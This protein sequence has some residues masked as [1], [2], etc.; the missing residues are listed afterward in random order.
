MLKQVYATSALLVSIAGLTAGG[1]FRSSPSDPLTAWLREQGA[2][3]STDP[4]LPGNPIVEVNFRHGGNVTDDDLARIEGLTEL[5][6]L[7]VPDGT[8]DAGMTR[9]GRLKKLQWLGLSYT[10][11]SDDGL[12]VVAGFDRL[13]TLDLGELTTD[14]G[15]AHLKGLKRLKDLHLQKASISDAGLVVVGQLEDL[16]FLSLDSTK[17]SDAGLKHIKGLKH[18]TDLGLRCTKVT[19]AG[20]ADLV[21]LPLE[22]LDLLGTAITDAG[23]VHLVKMKKLEKLNLIDTHV[24]EDGISQL[25]RALPN[26]DVNETTGWNPSAAN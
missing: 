25:R 20:L 16:S 14:A 18:L 19:D 22:K 7:G 4:S 10:K 8:T 3:V 1:C 15:L 13:E 12:R 24:S 2:I 5:R 21:G 23:I 6:G 17:V 26:C 9:L 11:V